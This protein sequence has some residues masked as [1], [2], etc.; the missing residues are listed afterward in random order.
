MVVGGWAN[1]KGQ[2]TNYTQLVD[3]SSSKTCGNFAHYPI[4]IYGATGALVSEKKNPVICGGFQSTESQP[5]GEDG[6]AH[7]KCHVYDK[8]SKEWKFLTNMTTEKGN[9]AS[10][11]LN[12]ALFVTGGVKNKESFKTTEFVSLNGTVMTGPD[13][14]SPRYKHCMV[15]LPSADP[16]RSDKV[17]IIGGHVEPVVHSKSVM[18]FDPDSKNITKYENMPS[19][20]YPT[21]RAG[22][23]V[24]KSPWH[25]NRSVVL[26]V[27]GYSQ[28]EQKPNGNA[29]V[30]D[31]TQPKANWTESKFPI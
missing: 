15:V 7:K 19:L 14:P 30:Y 6:K 23:A 10:V 1:S 29:E 13:L 17:M 5:K 21:S 20:I 11:Q 24:F 2:G 16:D 27:G 31:Y 9:I 4:A 18:I 26:S 12:G 22:C 28:T 25:G 8:S 3:L